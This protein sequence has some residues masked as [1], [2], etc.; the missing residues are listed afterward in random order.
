MDFFIKKKK[1]NY[2][3]FA[4]AECDKYDADL[5]TLM[6]ATEKFIFFF[7]SLSSAAQ[8]TADRAKRPLDGR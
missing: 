8:K 7:L 6:I 5:M 4:N 1:R 2:L 3:C